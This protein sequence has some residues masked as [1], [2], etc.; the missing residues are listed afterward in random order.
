MPATE[1]PTIAPPDPAELEARAYA[2]RVP[3]AQI[4]RKCRVTREHMTNVLNGKA[5]GSADLLNSVKSYLDEVE[6]SRAQ[7]GTEA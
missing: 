4:A 7:A 5:P 3:K 6:A 1:S 2:M